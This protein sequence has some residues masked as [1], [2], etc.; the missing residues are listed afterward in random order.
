VS[1]SRGKP[2]SSTCV[3][4]TAQGYRQIS[5]QSLCNWGYKVA[6]NWALIGGALHCAGRMHTQ[7]HYISASRTTALGVFCM[8]NALRICG[9]RQKMPKRAVAL[10]RKRS[11]TA[12]CEHAI[13]VAQRRRQHPDGPDYLINLINGDFLNM[14]PCRSVHEI[15]GPNDISSTVSMAKARATLPPALHQPFTTLFTCLDIASHLFSATKRCYDTPEVGGKEGSFLPRY[16]TKLQ[17]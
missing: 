12:S 10:S 4:R 8:A 13:C 11:A 5:P 17:I 16:P 9:S 15:S 14:S 3:S 7:D 1:L 2:T 6:Y